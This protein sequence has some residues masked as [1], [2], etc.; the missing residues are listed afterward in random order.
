MQTLRISAT[1]DT[2]D[3]NDTNKHE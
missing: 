2:N 3:T 1:N